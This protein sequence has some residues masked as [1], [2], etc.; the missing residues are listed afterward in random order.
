MRLNVLLQITARTRT[1]STGNRICGSENR[2]SHARSPAGAWAPA[3][4]RAVSSKEDFVEIVIRFEHTPCR[5]GNRATLRSRLLRDRSVGVGRTVPGKTLWMYQMSQ[6][7]HA[8]DEARARSGKIGV[9]IDSVDS[10]VLD[11][12]QG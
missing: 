4:W 3:S 8:F 5:D 12:R 10:A 1:V 2:I 7:F 6:Q 11:G 9:G